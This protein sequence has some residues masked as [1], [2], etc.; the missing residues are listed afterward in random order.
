MI[1]VHIIIL[2]KREKTFF[3]YLTLYDNKRLKGESKLMHKD[4]KIY[5]NYLKVIINY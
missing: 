5:A 3:N 4:N 2:E 1:V